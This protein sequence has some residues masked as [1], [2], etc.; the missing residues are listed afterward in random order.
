[1]IEYAYSVIQ[2]SIF[3]QVWRNSRQS[4]RANTQAKHVAVRHAPTSNP[5]PFFFHDNILRSLLEVPSDFLPKNKGSRGTLVN[6]QAVAK[7]VMM[8]SWQP[9][10]SFC[11]TR[12]SARSTN[13]CIRPSRPLVSN[14]E[15]DGVQI[16]LTNDQIQ[17]SNKSSLP[18]THWH[19]EPEHGS[20][21]SQRC[22]GPTQKEK[23]KIHRISLKWNMPH[24]WGGSFGWTVVTCT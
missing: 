14:P 23:W 2:C 8:R 18:S 4:R 3:F 22:V 15:A 17:L 9:L 19:K 11:F 16:S 6:N 12:V 20:S 24:R 10:R 7:Q 1:M 5:L 13:R 21:P